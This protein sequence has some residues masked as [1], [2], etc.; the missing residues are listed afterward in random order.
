MNADPER[1]HADWLIAEDG[2][3]ASLANA[4]ETLFTTGN[5][6]LGT[7]GCLAESHEGALPGT[8]LRGVFDHHDSAVP[9]LVEA[10]DWLTLSVVVNGTRLDVRSASVVRHRR[11]LD[12]REGPVSRATVFEESAG[13]P[14]PARDCPFRQQRRRASVLPYSTDHTGE[15]QRPNDL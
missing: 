13:A 2:F 8:F 9:E 4:H 1:E 11:T 6:Y 10:P 3:T 15:P 7:R 14:D 5:G 12:M